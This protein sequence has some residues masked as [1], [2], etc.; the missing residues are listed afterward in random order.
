MRLG[1]IVEDRCG[2]KQYHRA[3]RPG[4]FKSIMADRSQC[5]LTRHRRHHKSAHAHAD[6]REDSIPCCSC[7][8]HNRLVA[9]LSS[10]P[11]SGRRRTKPTSVTRWP[12]LHLV[13]GL[14]LRHPSNWNL[15]SHWH[16]ACC[17]GIW[18]V[19]RPLCNKVQAH[20]GAA[21]T[22]AADSVLIGLFVGSCKSLQLHVSYLYRATSS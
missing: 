9:Q 10:S 13:A 6:G 16:H 5:P 14:L 4:S 21:D 15:R 12:S 20:D 8:Y 22:H 18:R 1:S 2:P 17:N 3:A 19:Q 11:R 7:L